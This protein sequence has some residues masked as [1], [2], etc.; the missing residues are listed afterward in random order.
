MG[1]HPGAGNAHLRPLKRAILGF[2][3]NGNDGVRY[4]V[5]SLE[6]CDASALDVLSGFV[7]GFWNVVQSDGS[8]AGRRVVR[9]GFFLAARGTISGEHFGEQ[10]G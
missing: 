5:R 10:Y 7:S 4:A 2:T 8:A 3:C 9:S 6:V 1:G